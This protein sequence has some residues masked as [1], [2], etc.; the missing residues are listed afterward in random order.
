MSNIEDVKN[1]FQSTIPKGKEI[2]IDEEYRGETEVEP[3][4]KPEPKKQLKNK[5]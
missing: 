4:V 5:G 2:N 3:E 1:R